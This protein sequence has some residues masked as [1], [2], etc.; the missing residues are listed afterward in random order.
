MLD[1]SLQKIIACPFQY[2]L[3]VSLN[4]VKA[5]YNIRP[6]LAISLSCPAIFTERWELDLSIKLHLSKKT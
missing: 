2:K 6:L 4:C 3:N 1:D 5:I